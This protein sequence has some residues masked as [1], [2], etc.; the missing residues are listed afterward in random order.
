VSLQQLHRAVGW[1][2]VALGFAHV[3][4]T[5]MFVPGLGEPAL[6]FASGGGA[7]ILAGALNI[8]SIRYATVAPELAKVCVVTNLA[9]TAFLVLL[10]ATEGRVTIEGTVIPNPPLLAL[11]LAATASVLSLTRRTS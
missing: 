11:A 5:P 10:A 8:L 3:L 1:A 4:L 9:V 2:I 6:W 7:F